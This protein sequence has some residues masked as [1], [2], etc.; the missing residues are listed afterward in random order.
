MAERRETAPVHHAR[1]N[2]RSLIALW[3]RRGNELLSVNNRSP[4]DCCSS[5]GMKPARRVPHSCK[6]PRP[7]TAERLPVSQHRSSNNHSTM[8]RG[9]FSFILQAA[10]RRDEFGMAGCIPVILVLYPFSMRVDGTEV[11][12]KSRQA[13]LGQAFIRLVS[14]LSSSLM[15]PRV[16]LYDADAAPWMSTP[17]PQPSP[18]ASRP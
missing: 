14:G 16:Y 15:H 9:G 13:S 7:P 4:T 17:G 11:V 5:I 10:S 2:A 1:A 12:L 18:L 6:A 3:A 8:G